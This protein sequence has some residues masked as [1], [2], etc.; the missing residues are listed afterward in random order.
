MLYYNIS[1]VT[2]LGYTAILYK[3]DEH[4]RALYYNISLQYII[5]LYYHILKKHNTIK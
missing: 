5:F 2:L 1:R 4:T 3:Y